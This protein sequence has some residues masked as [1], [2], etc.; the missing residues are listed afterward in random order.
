MD[1]LA[2]PQ[3][4]PIKIAIEVVT[5]RQAMNSAHI[6]RHPAQFSRMA[7]AQ[8]IHISYML[9]AKRRIGKLL[10]RVLVLVKGWNLNL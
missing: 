6:H 8:N 1:T 7:Q 4:K 10:S 9:T 5:T 2:Y 3:P